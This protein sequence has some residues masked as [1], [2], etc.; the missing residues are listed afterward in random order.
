MYIEPIQPT[1]FKCRK[2]SVERLRDYGKVITETG[3]INKKKLDIYTAYTN[4][5]DIIHK[6][7]YLADDVGNWIK[8]KLKFYKDGKCYKTIRS[9]ARHDR[10]V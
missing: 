4:E 5:G 9:E 1:S 7:Y 10:V 6:L 2:G 3:I 8:S